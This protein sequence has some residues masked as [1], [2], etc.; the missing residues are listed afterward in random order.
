M[1]DDMVSRQVRPH[2]GKQGR[3]AQV[4]SEA[5]TGTPPVAVRCLLRGTALLLERV[6]LSSNP[7]NPLRDHGLTAAQKRA[8][9][10]FRC[11]YVLQIFLSPA[12]RTRDTYL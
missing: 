9:G 2:G 10:V 6:H 5:K 11:S 1:A 7:V 4:A 3:S 8:H 12:L